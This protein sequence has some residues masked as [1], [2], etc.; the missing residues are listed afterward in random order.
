MKIFHLNFELTEADN[1]LYDFIDSIL[2]YESQ[3]VSITDKGLIR[4]IF[5]YPIGVI[6]INC[7]GGLNRLAAI[8]YD[9]LKDRITQYRFVVSGIFSSNTFLIFG[10]LNPPIIEFK[11]QCYACIHMSSYSVEVRELMFTD[12]THHSNNFLNHIIEYNKD[13]L[14][15]Y[16]VFLNKTE[17]ISVKNGGDVDVNHQRLIKIFEKLKK[18]KSFQNKFKKIFELTC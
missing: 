9:F 14:D 6:Y 15:I 5:D 2:E 16:K 3:F 8:L 13:L 11:R 10:A 4:Q 12:L 17:L 1:K 7:S 18:S